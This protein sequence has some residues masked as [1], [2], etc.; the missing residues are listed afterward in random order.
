MG[1]ENM[2]I[3]DIKYKMKS[4]GVHKMSKICFLLNME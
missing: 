4:R 1:L 3:Y 2:K